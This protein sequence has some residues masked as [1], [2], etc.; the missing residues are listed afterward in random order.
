MEDEQRYRSNSNFSNR[1]NSNSEIE[2][3]HKFSS[4]LNFAP[5]INSTSKVYFKKNI[6]LSLITH[7][8]CKYH[9]E[10]F[11]FFL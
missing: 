3:H 5:K 9:K 6:R 1:I 4:S 10:N 8:F 11:Y 2:A 7:R